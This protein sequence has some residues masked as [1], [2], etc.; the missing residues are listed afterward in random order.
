MKIIKSVFLLLVISLLCLGWADSWEQIRSNGGQ[1]TSIQADFT[2]EKHLKILARPII[3]SGIF[4]FQVPGSL[5]WQYFSPVQ[6]LLLMHEGKTR[7]FVQQGSKLVE[8]RSMN[9]DGMQVISQEISQWLAGRFTDNPTFQA[10]LKPG[11]M[12]VLT[13]RQKG[14][15]QLINRIELIL[16]DQP[17]VLESVTIYEDEDSFTR[18]TFSNAVLNQDIKPTIFTKQ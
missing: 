13:P 4:V 9:M 6:S 18:L 10:E 14:L 5:R 11:R 16:S 15:A 17:G 12:I 2:Q 3:S 1:L 7:K 8:E